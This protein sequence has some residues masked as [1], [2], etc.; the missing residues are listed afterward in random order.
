[1]IETMEIVFPG[2]KRVNALYKIFVIQTDKPR[3]LGGEGAAP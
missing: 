3:E 2:G 1:M